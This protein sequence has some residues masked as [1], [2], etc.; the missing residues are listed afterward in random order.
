[1]ISK[2]IND[3]PYVYF[4][5]SSEHISKMNEVVSSNGCRFECGSVV[6]NGSK[7]QFSFM[8]TKKDFLQQYPDAELITEGYKTKMKFSNP[9]SIDKRG[10]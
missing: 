6:V 4:F 5:Y 8:S 3:N 10:N 7:R 1:M 2:K 9:K